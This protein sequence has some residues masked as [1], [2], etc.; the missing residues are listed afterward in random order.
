MDLWDWLRGLK[1]WWWMLV[2]FPGLAAV[3]T[4]LLAPQPQ[5]TT[6]WT[7]NI[8]FDDPQYANN[9]NYFD[10]LLLDDLDSLMRSGALGDVMYLKLPEGTQ[11]D[12]SRQEFGDM[13]QSRRQGRSVA[14]TIAGDDADVVQIV[15]ETITANLENVA[16]DYLLP[17]D[18]TRG[19]VTVNV[20]DEIPAPTL[21]TTTRLVTVGAVTFGT[22]LLSLAATGVAEWLRMSYRA[23]NSAK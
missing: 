19:P 2:L 3:T 20:L 5:Y 23:K 15:A 18:N 13:I 22:I 4:W 7:V 12:I 1:R 11:T 17:V 14:I 6:T 10:F 16:N 21:D 8:L 9:Q